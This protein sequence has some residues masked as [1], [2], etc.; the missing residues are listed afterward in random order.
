MSAAHLI[1][2]LGWTLLHFTWQ[3]ALIGGMTAA[4]LAATA[5]ARAEHRYLV[6]CSALLA[7]LLWPAMELV[8][9]LS[10]P[11]GAGHQVLIAE[12]LMGKAQG[13]GMTIGQQLQDRMTLI[14]G[15]WAL[16]AAGLTVRMGLGLLWIEQV[17]MRAGRYAS[18]EWQACITRMA[19]QFSVGRTVQMRIVDQLASPITAGWWRPV[20][21][22]PA[23]L[24]S[25]MPPDLL[26][27]LLAHEMGHIKRHDFVINLIQHAIEIVLFYHPAVWWISRQ[28]RNEREAIADDLA[29]GQLGEPRRLALALSELEKIQFSTHHLAQAANGGDLMSRIKRLIRPDTQATNWKAVIP[30]VSLAT[31]TLAACTSIAPPQA[32]GLV[33]DPTVNAY[34]DFKSCVKPMYPSESLRKQETGT[35]RMQFEISAEGKVLGSKV[36]KSSGSIPL[37]EAAHDAIKLC[38]FIPAQLNGKPVR[39]LM[40]MQYIWTLTEPKL[41]P[42]EKSTS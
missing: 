31:L 13:A 21:L 9:R 4:L 5:N 10:V 2:S 18:P 6:A 25:G 11:F 7:C 41:V 30:V 34:A 22:M 16:C 15:L 42:K 38:R 33:A 12:A 35:V 28:V 27:A 26:E 17:G 37:D 24:M 32:D 1:D 39:A 3:G 8:Q 40:H 36:V 20:I 19:E 23:S 29:A 14:V